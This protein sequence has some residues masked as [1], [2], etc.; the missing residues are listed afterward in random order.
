MITIKKIARFLRAII[1][2]PFESRIIRKA[3][4]NLVK[5][6]L[7]K[8]LLKKEIMERISALKN[9]QK[10]NDH[11]LQQLLKKEFGDRLSEENV[12]LQLRN[13]NL[14]VV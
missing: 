8:H 2:Y 9:R 4:K 5:N 3:E 13:G 7:Q 6:E 14:R 12:K 1:R 10:M 11:H